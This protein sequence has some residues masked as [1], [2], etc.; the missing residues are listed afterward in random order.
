[1]RGQVV[2]RVGWSAIGGFLEAAWASGGRAS[3]TGLLALCGKRST[4]CSVLLLMQKHAHG[5][6]EQRCA[7]AELGQCVHRVA[8]SE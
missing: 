4:Y 6:R 8:R 2:V 7:R 1:M 3:D 5:E